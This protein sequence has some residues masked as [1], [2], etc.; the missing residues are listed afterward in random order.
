MKHLDIKLYKMEVIKGK[1]DVAREWLN[2]L[3]NSKEE[4]V[5]TLKN[6][7]V[8]LESYFMAE[9][10]GTMFVYCF[11]A[12]DN[13]DKANQIASTSNNK[14][15]EQHF[16]YGAECISQTSGDIMDCFLYIENLENL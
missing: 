13:I 1:E 15:D 8:Y 16:K 7:K 14:L 5:Q 9:E 11:M 4:A 10:D 6:E 2:F 12:A 3:K